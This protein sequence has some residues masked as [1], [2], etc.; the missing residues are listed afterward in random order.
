MSFIGNAGAITEK[1]DGDPGNNGLSPTYRGQW[2]KDALYINIPSTSTDPG[3]GDIVY[4]DGYMSG[5]TQYYGD[6]NTKYYIC[7]KDI[8]NIS[9]QDFPPYIST[10]QGAGTL[11]STYWLEFGD[12]F[13]N[14]ATNILLTEEAYITDKLIIGDYGSSGYILSNGFTG[15][16]YDVYNDAYINSSTTYVKKINC[17]YYD[18]DFDS[19][20]TIYRYD[21]DGDLVSVPI[22]EW[23]GHSIQLDSNAYS[24]L[25]SLHRKFETFGPVSPGQTAPEVMILGKDQFEKADASFYSGAPG[26]LLARPDDERVIF[27]MGGTGIL[28]NDSYIRFDSSKGKIE[29]AG[30]FINNTILAPDFDVNGLQFLDDPFGAFVGG[31]YNNFIGID[32]EGDFNSLGSAITAGAW[33]TMNSRFSFIGAGYSGDCRDN[34]SAIVAGYGNSMPLEE[35]GDH[36]GA[37]LIGCGLENTI[38]GGTSQ[39]IVNGS[40]NLIEGKTG[41][42]IP[43]F[44]VDNS[45]LS[46]SLLGENDPSAPSQ[47]ASFISNSPGWVE[48]IWFP[49]GGINSTNI[50]FDDHLYAGLLRGSVKGQYCYHADFKWIYISPQLSFNYKN[51]H[52]LLYP[53]APQI[54]LPKFNEEAGL[55]IYHEFDNNTYSDWYFWNKATSERIVGTNIIK[56]IKLSPTQTWFYFRIANNVLQGSFNQGGNFTN[57]F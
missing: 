18:Y 28:G 12:E 34:F 16:L 14:V 38:S 1:T 52:L 47:N 57:M 31:G 54:F 20:D 46:R 30:T 17:A 21:G 37:N 19:N 32:E 5:T 25:P 24:Y 48:N 3:R 13:E 15:G 33:N 51:N 6:P 23:E 53:G 35:P 45:I 7:I 40:N 50:T 42:F 27:D 2:D 22:S 55:W 44:D 4:Y 10:Q 39:A 56:A 11:N 29:I 49:G 36:Q 26:F 43:L 8:P 9:S 41:S